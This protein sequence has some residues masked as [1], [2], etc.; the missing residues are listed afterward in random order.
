MKDVCEELDGNFITE[1]LC[2]AKTG[3][4]GRGSCTKAPPNRLF[5]K[6]NDMV[7]IERRAGCHKESGQKT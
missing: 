3:E 7:G 2:R 5:K 6:A 1:E 4:G